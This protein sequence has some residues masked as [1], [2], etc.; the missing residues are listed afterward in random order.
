[1]HSLA[2]ASH[3]KFHQQWTALPFNCDFQLLV[4]HGDWCLPAKD[5]QTPT[6]Y[7]STASLCILQYTVINR[8]SR[9]CNSRLHAPFKVRRVQAFSWNPASE[10]DLSCEVRQ[11]LPSVLPVLSEHEGPAYCSPGTKVFRSKSNAAS[12]VRRREVR[13]RVRIPISAATKAARR[14]V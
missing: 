4:L 1:M 8:D 6:I 13:N 10:N 12:V 11:R 14:P 9:R 3:G 5:L 2:L 7:V